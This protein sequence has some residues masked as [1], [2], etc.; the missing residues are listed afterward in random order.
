MKNSR[1]PGFT[2][3]ELMIVLVVIGV[4][5]MVGLPSYQNSVV[6]S[7]RSDAQGTLMG[8]AQAMER[9]YNQN[10]S[11]D[12]AAAGGTT[13]G[14]PD[15]SVFP[16][17][18]PLDGQVYY[19]LTIEAADDAGFTI[20]ATPIAGSRQDG[21][22]IIELDSLGRRGWDQDNDGTIAATERTWERG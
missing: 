19:N 1:N 10:Y 18:A 16:D 13:T 6:R 11:Y 22:G 17:Q 21:D 8:F 2:L 7:S 4:L 5:L 14:A 9:F 15:G 3:I 20:R 12:G